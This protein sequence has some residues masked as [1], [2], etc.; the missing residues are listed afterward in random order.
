[1]K[2]CIKCDNP[3]E[4]FYKHRGTKDGLDTTCKLC[5]AKRAKERRSDPI[6]GAQIVERKRR[7][8]LKKYGI[9][10]EIYAI[11]HEEQLGLCD[12]CMKPEK[13]KS[14]GKVH[15]LCVDHCHSTGKVRGLL[16]SECNTGIGKLGDTIEGLE[17]A[18]AYLKRTS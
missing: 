13:R 8:D 4:G 10:P 14:Y 9:T 11:M 1:M 3:S 6:I 5:M 17:K 7:S 15:G 18:L 2:E 16:C 12:I